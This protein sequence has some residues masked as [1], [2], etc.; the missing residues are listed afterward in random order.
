MNWWWVVSFVVLSVIVMATR[1]SFQEYRKSQ[2][3]CPKCCSPLLRMGYQ[4]LDNGPSLD[5]FYQ[6]RLTKSSICPNKSCELS[7]KWNYGEP[8]KKYVKR[9]FLS[10]RYWKYRRLLKR[11]EVTVRLSS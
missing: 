8:Y 10:V 2:R 6:L 9:S 1:I 4:V 7:G 5:G 11:G 3:R